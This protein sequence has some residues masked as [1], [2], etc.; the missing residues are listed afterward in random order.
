MNNPGMGGEKKERPLFTRG[1]GKK[2]TYGKTVWNMEGLDNF[3]T[4]RM[5][6]IHGSN[7]LHWSMDGRGGSQMTRQRGIR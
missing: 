4:G 5:F 3:Y 6:T 7:F 2:R 1:E